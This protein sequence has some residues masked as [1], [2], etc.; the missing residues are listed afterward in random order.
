MLSPS[1][2]LRR[3]R[4]DVSIGLVLLNAG[5][6]ANSLCNPFMYDDRSIILEDARVQ[7]GDWTALLTGRYWHLPSATRHYRP[8]ISLSYAVNQA[9]SP[10]PWAYRA[11][12]LM[13]HAGTSVVL[14]L[15][16]LELFGSLCAAAAA[17]AFFALHPVHT[18]ALNAIV[19]RADLVVALGVV[20]A[21]WIYWRDSAPG[22]ARRPG[23]PV[24]GAAAFAVAL[25][26]KENAVTLLGVV[27]LLDWWRRRQGEATDPGWWRRRVLRAYV[28]MILILGAYLGTREVLLDSAPVTKPPT[29]KQIDNPI[30]AHGGWPI[31]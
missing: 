25:L 26:C 3:W 7:Q 19:G 31:K 4:V 29:L 17:G 1:S 12:N 16:T 10:E 9:L 30:A 20:C 11:A 5:V 18:E 6:Y 21:A 14:F 8:L 23:R 27:A 2:R 13:L 22:A 28:P 15:F 24:A